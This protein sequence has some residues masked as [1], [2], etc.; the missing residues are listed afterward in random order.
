[1]AVRFVDMD[2]ATTEALQGFVDERLHRIRF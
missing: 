2:E 1:M